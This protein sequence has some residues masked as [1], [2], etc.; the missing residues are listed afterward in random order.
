MFQ[1]KICLW[2]AFLKAAKL[3]LLGRQAGVVISI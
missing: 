2:Y 1:K 3:N